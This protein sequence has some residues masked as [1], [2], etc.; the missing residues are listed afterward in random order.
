M[1]KDL[2]SLIAVSVAVIIFI[3]VL[4]LFDREQKHKNVKNN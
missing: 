1:D 2:I 4:E 3:E